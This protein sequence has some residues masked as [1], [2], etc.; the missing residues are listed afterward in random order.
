MLKLKPAKAASCGVPA[1]GCSA[2]PP[3]R[4]HETLVQLYGWDS[5]SSTWHGPTEFSPGHA[6]SRR[7]L[8]ALRSAPG[9]SWYGLVHCCSRREPATR[10]FTLVHEF[11]D[12]A[13]AM[14]Y[15]NESKTG[16][17]EILA[18]LPAERRSR[19]RPEFAFEFLSFA[20]FLG[21]VYA[22][23]ELRVHDAIAAAIAETRDSD[24]LVFSIGSGLWPS[25]REYVLSE[26]VEK[27][28]VT[29]LQWLGER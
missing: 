28:A 12:C 20:S 27:V 6:P 14:I 23:A 29:L 25:D 15:C 16:P 5:P 21:S 7:L 19:L 22:G 3:E 9:Q 18:V 1:S 8:D 4:C 2:V 10:F 17:V 26:C 13:T 24:S 11:A